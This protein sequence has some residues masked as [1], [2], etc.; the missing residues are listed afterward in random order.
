MVHT[1]QAI[2]GLWQSVERFLTTESHYFDVIN[3]QPPIVKLLVIS[4]IDE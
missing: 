1:N 3:Q 4:A 2:D